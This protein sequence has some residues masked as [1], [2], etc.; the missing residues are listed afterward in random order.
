MEFVGCELLT[1]S[2]FDCDINTYEMLLIV[3]YRAYDK[4]ETINC[5][6]IMVN[7]VLS[8]N[9]VKHEIVSS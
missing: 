3:N 5:Y 6:T 4:G 7:L 9:K 1:F 8:V 2:T